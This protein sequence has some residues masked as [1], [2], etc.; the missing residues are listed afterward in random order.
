MRGLIL[1]ALVLA[2]IVT[3][4]GLIAGAATAPPRSG[5]DLAHILW[6]STLQAGLST[7][8]SLMVGTML[9]VALNRLQFAGRA[10]LVGLFSAALVTPGIVLAFGLVAV[11]GRAGWASQLVDEFTGTNPGNALYGLA[12]IVVAHTLLD[13]AFAARILLARLDALPAT[14]LKLGQSLG[15]GPLARLRHLDWPALRGAMPG[16]AALIFLLAFTSFPI[17]LLLGGGPGAE[18][19]EAAIYAA[20]R[21][22]FDLAA[23]A[24]MAALQVLVCGLI[25][26]PA[27]LAAP[28]AI[29]AGVRRAYVWGERPVVAALYALILALGTLA[30]AAPLVSVLAAGL[31]SALPP[32]FAQPAF[33][34]AALASLGIG[35]ASALLAL[36]LAY[37]IAA[38]LAAPPAAGDRPNRLLAL[39]I[40]LPAFAYLA[41]PAVM[42]SLGFFLA[43]RALALPTAVAAPPV[44]I[45]ANALMTLPFAVAT[46]RPALVAIARRYDRLTRSLGLAGPARLWRIELP[47]LAPE[48][49][50]VLA[51]GFCFSLGDLGVIYLFGTEDFATL[52]W[53]MVRALGAYRS[54]DAAA[55]AALLLAVAIAAFTI[56]PALMSRIAHADPR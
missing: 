4:L 15:L 38:A 51:I 18:T 40:G 5:V 21:L 25:I 49:G 17:V 44:L 39:A 24:R 14:R 12:G 29:A 53:L 7:L 50:V 23:A 30:F 27:S 42:L 35:T 22:D 8:F 2:L 26:L 41:V 47:L 13:G 11:W 32:L 6:F 9:A 46:L 48:I 52:P 43:A 55:I 20:I 16:L 34:R 1:S 37:V 56:L 36:G 3:L 28:G 45:V 10:L 19:L 54:A 31:G 33:W